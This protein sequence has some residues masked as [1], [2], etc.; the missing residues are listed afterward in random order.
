AGRNIQAD[1]IE[2]ERLFVAV[3]YALDLGDNGVGHSG[4]FTASSAG[5]GV[6]GSVRRNASPRTPVLTWRW[7]LSRTA[8]SAWSLT[9]KISFWR[10]SSVSTLFSVNCASVATKLI[11]FGNT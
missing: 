5:Q 4:I 6:L 1:I 11:V 2:R 3:R 8:R 7:N 10:S 9:R